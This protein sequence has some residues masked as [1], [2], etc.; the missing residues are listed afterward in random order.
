MTP[1]TAKPDPSKA[2]ASAT[3][4]PAAATPSPDPG[5]EIAYC[6]I[7]PGVGIARIGN[8]PD[9]FFIGPLAPGEVPEPEG[10][11]KDA[12]GRIKRQGAEFRVYAYNK[13]GVAIKEVTADDADITWT[14]HVANRKA[15]YDMFLGRFWQSQYPE[16]STTNPDHTPPRNQEVTGDDRRALVIDPGPRSISGRSQKPVLLDGGV[17]GPLP[18][19]PITQPGLDD[20]DP[21][22]VQ[23]T[24]GNAQCVQGSRTGYMNV[25]YSELSNAPPESCLSQ[26]KPGQLIPPVAMSRKVEVPLGELRTDDKG[27]LIFVGGIGHSDSLIPDN[28]IGFLN[29]DSFF[30]N[31]DY[32][33]DDTSDGPVSASVVLK[34]G[35]AVEV[36]DKAWV[37]TAPPKYAPAARVLTTLYEIA[38]ET[39]EKKNPP[40]GGTPREVSFTSDI[41]PVL[42]R[43]QQYHWLNAAAYRGHGPGSGLANDFLGDPKLFQS[44]REKGSDNRS[45]KV[46]VFNRLRKPDLVAQ[47]PNTADTPE[48]VKYANAFYMPQMSGDGG[49]PTNYPADGP[50]PG[51]TYIT[52]L[53]LTS[54][55]YRKFEAWS[56]D[57][58]VDDWK[59]APPFRPIWSFPV[60][61]QPAMLD[62]GAL[63]P[64]VGGA[65]YPG[66]EI[67]YI[68]TH[69]ETWSGLCRINQ[70]WQ[71]GDVTKHM[72]VPWQADFSECN[73]NWWPA[74]RPDNVVPEALYEEI[75]RTYNPALMGKLEAVLS[76][77][78]LWA[79]GIPTESPGL[80]NAMVT[81]WSD[82]GFVVP[83]QYPRD[84]PSAQTVYIE[85]ERSP[86]V[87]VGMRDAFYYL[88]NIDNYPDFLAKA[89]SLVEDFLAQAWKNQDN[90]DPDEVWKFFP[91]TQA[92]FDARMQLIYDNYVRDNQSDE[93]YQAML[94]GTRE[95]SIY[96]LLQLGPFN[97]LDGAWLRRITPDGP[98]SDVSELLFRIRMDELGDGNVQQNHANVYTDLLKSVNIYLPDLYTR[99]Y[100]D[101]PRFLDSAFVE[102]VFLLAISQF[103]DEF[104]PE[105]LGMTLELEWGSVSLVQTVNQ[106]EAFGINPLYYQLHVGIDNASAGHGALAKQ[107]VEM[108]L[109]L[110]RQN[111]GEAAMQEV[112]KRIWTGY[113]AFGTL[114]TLG[115]DIQARTQSPPT[116]TDRMIALIKSKT[117]YGSLMH[118]HKM[119]GPNEI[120]DWFEDPTGF[121][122]ALQEAGIVVPGQPNISPIMQL[123]GFNGPMYHVFTDEERD[124]WRDW[125]LSLP[126]GSGATP[127][128]PTQTNPYLNM[129]KV[130][131]VLRQRQGGVTGHKVLLIGPDPET[132]GGT[133]TRPV[134]WWFDLNRT[135]PNDADDLLMQALSNEENGWIVKG[136]AAQSPLVTSLVTGN[137]AM[138]QV[139]RTVAPGTGGQ[140]YENI[141]VAWIDAGCPIAAPP[142]RPMAMAA[143]F[144][145]MSST[146]PDRRRR[147]IW[148][149]G[150]VH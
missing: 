41:Y 19:T 110:V 74:Q 65:F 29:V 91:Y 143:R 13:D 104:F 15:E 67:T 144:G 83:R 97:Q 136:N 145:A 58:Y 106:L 139:F 134:H 105:L 75:L 51:G 45:A 109:D 130:I 111:E 10:G 16:F 80:D 43:M 127:P 72:A 93:V 48:S 2:P 52:W 47:S 114:G 8:S 126:T 68:A 140:T 22:N 5:A 81:A 14:V 37:L 123:T 82:F 132:Q 11:F 27:R 128:P 129:K 118:G 87:Q 86:Y 24:S 17:F 71:P 32:W 89:H 148:G 54:E 149:M 9:E 42:E 138:A 85:T 88:M 59:G 90:A 117:E 44:L 101:D 1:T 133:I 124:L 112:W 49:E 63:D 55:Q 66:I 20:S 34:N 141:I 135:R 3:P 102:P 30:A 50:T 73:T 21:Q 70:S 79:R 76:E 18:Y 78:P 57:R 103:D 146:S 35:R 113:V 12:L 25:I 56:Q 46:R 116:L 6:R 33:H 39:W 94:G 60:A 108:Y 92:A 125:I 150:V 7:H 84:E 53:T 38:L 147:R 122:V 100:A 64:C 142:A 40:R 62:K 98:V 61:E 26:W 95:A 96:Q 137:G 121:L 120:N 69:P 131:D 99:A 28:P 119:V 77:R 23:L 31:N 107:A 4:S 36:V 115:A